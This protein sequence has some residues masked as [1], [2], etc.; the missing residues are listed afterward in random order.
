MPNITQSLRTKSP[1]PF[2]GYNLGQNKWNIWITSAPHFNDAKMVRF[3]SFVPSPLLLGGM[4]L[5]IPF[6]SVQ[7]YLGQ[8]K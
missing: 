6:Y 7:D 5:I 4:G 2:L 3:C 1:S 8:N